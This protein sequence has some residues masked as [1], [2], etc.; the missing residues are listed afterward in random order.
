MSTHFRMFLRSL[1]CPDLPISERF[2]IFGPDCR[3][4]IIGHKSLSN[5]CGLK[6]ATSFTMLFA[7]HVC[8]LLNVFA[9]VPMTQFLKIG[10][11]N[12]SGLDNS[13]LR[14]VIKWLLR[15]VEQN[16]LEWHFAI[17][18]EGVRKRLN[19]LLSRISI[20]LGPVGH[21]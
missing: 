10:A 12:I 5:Y 18:F 20:L 17:I 14:Y 15:K 7:K 6:D 21:N 2:R 9:V 19:I 13:V 8:T 16:V 1:R 4:H 3:F 11:P